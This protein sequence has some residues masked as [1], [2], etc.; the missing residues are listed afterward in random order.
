MSVAASIFKKCIKCGQLWENRERFILDRG[1]EIIGYQVQ[2]RELTEGLFL[3]NHSCGGTLSITAGEFRDLYSG[4]IFEKR[5]TGT[6]ECPSYCMRKDELSSC[7]VECECAYV[8]EIIQ[9]LK[10]R[11]KK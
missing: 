5:A 9:L 4:P 2:F 3:F 1:I 8:R 10:S 11:F 6:E 7:P